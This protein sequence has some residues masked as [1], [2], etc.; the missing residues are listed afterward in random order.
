MR[1]DFFTP[2]L[3]F[4]RSFYFFSV[5]LFFHQKKKKEKDLKVSE[6]EEHYYSFA[7]LS[8]LHTSERE[9]LTTVIAVLLLRRIS[10]K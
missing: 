3:F 5:C 6:E 7:P 4:S 1:I 8:I 9:D 2:L 10:S